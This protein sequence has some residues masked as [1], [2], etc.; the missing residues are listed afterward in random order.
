[1]RNIP[2]ISLAGRLGKTAPGGEGTSGPDLY[3]F[4]RAA[5]IN[6]EHGREHYGLTLVLGG[7]EVSMRDLARLYAM[8]P[9]RGLLRDLAFFEE[10]KGGSASRLL[11]P[12]ACVLTLRMLRGLPAGQEVSGAVSSRAVTYGKTGTS[13]GF[14]DAWTAGVF[15]PYVLVVWVGNFDNTPNQ[16]FTGARLAAPLFTDIAEAVWVMEKFADL[17]LRRLEGLNLTRVKIC[18]DTGD[19][20]NRLCPRQEESW[21]IPGVSPIADSRIYRRILVDLESGLRACVDAPGRA[22]W[23]VWEFWPTDL[24]QLFQRAGIMKPSPPPFM[25]ECGIGE[26]TGG[27]PPEILSPKSGM[28]YHR[29]LSR[30]EGAVVILHASGDADVTE[31]FW[32]A[33]DKYIGRGSP[34]ERLSWVPPGGT[35]LLRVVDNFGR[36]GQRTVQVEL[37][38]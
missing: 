10:D 22:E 19:L 2:A 16:V 30:P 4:L 21:F 8:L 29:S 35:S 3:D 7:A 11:S 20:Y 34:D 18:S 33:G 1:S 5:G 24:R 36:S 13:N 32:F 27:L 12:E 9:N 17:P 23:Q 37:T 14:R 15:G 26:N 28:V 31:F 38:E 6:F 25:P